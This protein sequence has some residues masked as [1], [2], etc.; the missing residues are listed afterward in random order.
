VA[1]QAASDP[2]VVLVTAAAGAGIGAA[3]ARR[4]AADGASVVVTDRHAGRTAAV[5]AELAEQHGVK[6]LG[7]PLEVGDRAQ[8]YAVVDDALA[9]FGR[10]DVLVNNAA[11]NR[12]V[13]IHEMDPDEWDRIVRVDFTGA[14]DLTRAVLPT[15]YAR[16]KGAIVN[17]SSPASYMGG[18][19]GEGA[20]AA[21]KAALQSLTRTTAI[22]GGPRG[23]R[24]NAVAPGIVWNDFGN[25]LRLAPAEVWEQRKTEIPMGRFGR[26]EEVAAV[27]AFLASDEAS[28]V[29]GETIVIG[30]GAWLQP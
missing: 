11:V 27:V 23:V 10:I 25:L 3:V 16:Q 17:I 21:A 29:S 6:T 15:M 5:A 1:A 4:F 24:C 18:I 28:Y 8:A 12:L 30:G 13:E 9:H 20:Y 19:A 26:P 2:V 22:E 14:Y 7:L